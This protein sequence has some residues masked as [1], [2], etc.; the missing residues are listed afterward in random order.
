MTTLIVSVFV[1]SPAPAILKLS[2]Y[3]PTKASQIPIL[4]N[5]DRESS[6]LSLKAVKAVFEVPIQGPFQTGT[7]SRMQ[8]G[9]WAER[10][11]TDV[12]GC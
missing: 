8:R 12:I 2:F 3:C 6:L 9:H 10:A 5:L 11:Q 4:L 1:S 7:T